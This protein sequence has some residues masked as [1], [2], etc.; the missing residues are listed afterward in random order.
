M[1]AKGFDEVLASPTI[2]ESAQA[3]SWNL[4]GKADALTGQARFDEAFAVAETSWDKSAEV[5]TGFQAALFAA[6]AGGNTDRLAKVVKRWHDLNTGH[7]PLHRAFGSMS[8]SLLA[9]LER[10]WDAGRTAYVEAEQLIEGV[11]AATLLARFRLAFGHLGRGRFP[12]AAR[13]SEAADAFFSGRDAMAYVERYRSTAFAHPD[14]NANPG[15]IANRERT[16][17]ASG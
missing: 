8:A 1:A 13:A 14:S 5:E 15:P 17:R 12:E 4:A 16:V 9:L 10:R 2:V 6:V 11:G 7:L 3:T